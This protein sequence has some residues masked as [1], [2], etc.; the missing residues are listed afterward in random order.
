MGIM[1]SSVSLTRYRVVEKPGRDILAQVPEKLVRFAF[2]DIDN[3]A[4]ER[5]F[6]WVCFEDML[7]T[8][9]RKAPPEKGAYF[10]F[11]LRLDTRRISPAVLK[12][13]LQ[14][15]IESEMEKAKEDG[16][17]FL[18]RD[19][20]KE[21]REQIT[22]KLRARTLPVP[23]VF[24]VVWDPGSN[25]VWFGTT[26]AKARNLFEDCFTAT[27]DLNLEPLTPFFL[28][29]EKLGESKAARLENL[30]PTL[31]I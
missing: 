23:A 21:I 5:S 4:D 18:S 13:H 29:L 17:N 8:R 11:A 25:R 9:W 1:S 24:E 15:A 7:D 22:L 28:A 12:K 31:F 3:T 10:A 14:I 2:R 27:F 20:K 19:R 16:K 30:E 26:N 6:G